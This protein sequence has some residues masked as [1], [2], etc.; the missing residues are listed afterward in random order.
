MTIKPALAGHDPPIPFIYPFG[1]MI[2]PQCLNYVE[3]PFLLLRWYPGQ[4]S[5]SVLEP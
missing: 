1:S 3:A 2:A 4:A 5:V